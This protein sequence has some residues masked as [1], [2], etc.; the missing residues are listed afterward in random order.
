MFHLVDGI[1]YLFDAMMMGVVVAIML[2]VSVKY[3][4]KT[5]FVGALMLFMVWY[6][7]VIVSQGLYK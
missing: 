4:T 1:G 7:T 5:L 3:S 6:V 2:R